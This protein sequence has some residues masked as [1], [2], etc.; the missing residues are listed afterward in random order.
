MNSPIRPLSDSPANGGGAHFLKFD[1]GYLVRL[2]LSKAWFIILVALL[3]LAAAIVYLRITPNIYTSSATIEVQQEAQNVTN[4]QDVDTQDYKDI[5]ALKTVEQSLLS[6]TLLLRVVKANG[7]DKVPDFAPPRIDGSAYSDIELAEKFKSKLSVSLRRGTRLIDV[8]VEDKNPVRAQQL[9]SSMIKEYEALNFE[10]DASDTKAGNDALIQEASRLKDKLHKSEQ[11]LQQYREQYHAVSLEDKQN[12][13]VEKLKELNQKVTDA[14]SERIKLESDIA[15]IQHVNKKNP[16]QLLLL[17]SV[18]SLPVVAE[19]RKEISDK[20][21]EFAQVNER[22]GE[23][24][25]KWIEAQAQIKDLKQTLN[26]ALLNS[27]DLVTK[28]YEAAKATEDKLRAEL[29]D[30]EDSALEL[31]KIAIPYNVLVREE[32]SD[33]ALYDAVLRRM[34]ETNVQ[35]NVKENHIRVVESPMVPVSPSKPSKRKIL[36][37]A[38]LAGLILSCGTVVG[39][40]MAN[41]SIRNVSQ[42]EEL[43]GLPVLTSIPR[44]KR[45]RLDRMPVVSGDPASHE[46]EAFRSLRTALLFLG[47]TK[48]F[49]TVLFTSA[50]PGEGKTYCSLN[51]AAAL[52]QLGLRTLVIDADLRRPKLSKALLPDPKGPGLSDC[53]SGKASLLDCH[54]AT[55]TENL[56]I[57]GAGQRPTRPAELLAS[58]DLAGLLSEAKLHFDRIVLDSA[59]V[60]AVSDTQLV[61]REIELVCLVIWARKTP[62]HVL[63]RACDHLGWATHS[64]DAVILNRVLRGSRD[65]YHFARYASMYAKAN[66]YRRATKSG[67]NGS[68]L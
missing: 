37:F 31:N 25:P 63:I 33:R 42:A 68:V 41:T 44:S 15:T 52:A 7:L 11:A 27:A 6:D 40:D 9:A 62:R 21:A 12:I 26:R 24:H 3:C 58:G 36:A 29:K 53:L 50:N 65:Y 5:D 16:E 56:F 60:N 32:E 10:E 39:I 17:S 49:K 43:L 61:A 34:K 47:P 46:A 28:S 59:P 19:L 8:T 30:Q 51:C 48:D 1:F 38:V 54:Q 4:I 18:A 55:D 67:A 14:R 20:E 57:L 23:L 66:A 2:L 13:V 64:P 35:E 22:Y 45:K